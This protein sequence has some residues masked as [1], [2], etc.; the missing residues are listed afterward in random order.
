MNFRLP[1]QRGQRAFTF[2][3]LMVVCVLLVILAAVMIPEMRGSYQDALLRATGRK[4]MDAFDL[5]YSRAVSLDQE[6]RVRI[7][8]EGGRYVI[9]RRAQDRGQDDFEA[10]K[11]VAGGEGELDRRISIEVR[12]SSE[13]S[14][15]E[16]AEAVPAETATT[17]QSSPETEN[18]ISFY[19]D[20]TADDREV[21][22]RDQEGFRLA[23][24]INPITARINIIELERQ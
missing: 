4:L 8:T 12:N 7:D 21:I 18:A 13:D 24:R 14:T 15:N 2:I 23:L 6:D 11:D 1:N 10:L 16:T 19:P 9:E 17:D 3:E 5:A 20:G 22:L